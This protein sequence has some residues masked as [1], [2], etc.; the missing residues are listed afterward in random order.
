[1]NGSFWK[2]PRLAGAVAA[3]SIGYVLTSAASKAL[4]D[5]S[6]Q[7]P[8][9]W[10][11][12]VFAVALILRTP[13]L[14]TLAG[15]ATVFASALASNT[16]MGNG[17]A[18]TMIYSTA[19]A[20]GI[21]VGVA[22][23]RWRFADT[24]EFA[25]NAVNY[26]QTLALAGLLAPAIAATFFAPLAH[27]FAG[28]PV[29]YSFGRWWSGDA[30]AF[31]LFLPV[32]L[33]ASRET[34]SALS[35]PGVAIRLGLSFAASGIVVYL[36]LTQFDFPF[37]LIQVPL[38]IAA[39]RARPFELALA[40]LSTGGVLI[41][42]AMAG[43]VP[44]LSSANDF[45]IAVGI[46]V[47]LPFIAGLMVEE[48]RRERRRTAEQEQFYRRAMMDSEIG[49]SIAELDGKI[50][51]INDALAHMLGR[52]REDLEGVARWIDITY[53]PD[54]AIGTDMVKWVRETKSPNY[55]FEKR[56]LKADGIP[57]WARV[58]GS[59][60]YDDVSGE[61]L[62]M[63]S[64][65]VDIDA[66]KKSEAAIAE[67]ET[68]WNFALASAG[69][70]VW[71]V[72]MR[73]GRT[74][75][76]VTWTD[77]LGYQPGELDGD[78]SRW[79][80]FIHPDDRDR[81]MAADRAY[82][83]GSAEFF[84]AEF[85]MRRK[86]GSWIWI[87][88]RGKVTE[89]D[90]NG[91]MLRAIGTLTDISARKETEQR[92]EQSAKDLTAEKERL[93]V[94]LESIGDAVICTDG[95]GRIT[96]LNPVAEKLTRTPAA[97]ALG[98]PLAS[99]YHSVDED[100][101]E[102]LTPADPGAEANARHSSRAVLVRNDGSRCSIREVM[103]PIRSAN[104][105][106]AGQVLVFQDFTDARALQ[107]QLAYAA[108]H[109]ALTGLDNRASFMAAA[110]ALQ[111][112]TRQDGAR[113][114]LAFI[115]LDRFKAVNDSSGHAAGDALLRKVA[116]AIRSVVRTHGK[117]A[118]LGGDEFAVIFPACREEE[119]LAL[120]RAVVSAIA[121]LRFEWH[122]RVHSVGA[123]AGLASLDDGCGSI[124][125]VLAAADHAC[126]EAK[127]SGGGCVVARRLEPS[128]AMQ[129]RAVSGTR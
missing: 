29:P 21:G 18:M 46:S 84:E 103:S 118:R 85:R 76:S 39:W 79:L 74:S 19:N 13:A 110:D 57:I 33:L 115:D 77:M 59:V 38:L 56:Y 1:M 111:F 62:Y 104:G 96:F 102:T 54:R 31:S 70:G 123:S 81:V 101:G 105:A 100:T 65:V 24:R 82:S 126:Y 68:R 66:R 106:S 8:A 2:E 60:V 64:Q 40:C 10:F 73:K 113:P 128:P 28:W 14:G 116:A 112:E 95:E 61:P 99:V 25:R 124:D 109:D 120:T 12:N 48:S 75:Y 125:E 114:H 53:G 98:R 27:L 22:A 26:V 20:L 108:N 88:D 72:D 83:E 87:L 92:L 7:M 129:Q 86:D 51:R 4:F 90:E 44:H 50:V 49:V 11:A 52:R 30:M 93:R 55:S 121:A 71:D 6:A 91:R 63:V 36:A 97:E 3:L 78:T 35:P 119:A 5:P 41:G 80:T 67:A 47:V 127:A 15:A 117:V 34:L 32:M 23:V 42:L 43:L 58:S 89:R 69:Q 17:P 45:Q 16:V 107:R 37:V 9:V 122:E 94:T